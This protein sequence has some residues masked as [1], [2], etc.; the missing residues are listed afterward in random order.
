MEMVLLLAFLVAPVAFCSVLLTLVARWS[1]HRYDLTDDYGE[2]VSFPSVPADLWA[3][4]GFLLVV[5]V[6]PCLAAFAV[7]LS[8]DRRGR[9]SRLA[10]AALLVWSIVAIGDGALILTRPAASVRCA[11]CL[12]PD[13]EYFPRTSCAEQWGKGGDYFETV[14]CPAEFQEGAERVEQAIDR[15][16]IVLM[17]FGGIGVV[18]GSVLLVRTRRDG[19]GRSSQA[20]SG[21]GG[22]G[23]GSTD[24]S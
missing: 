23:E 11:A 16:A 22:P 18:A 9:G 12:D 3:L 4:R 21:G 20:G 6:L 15:D 1:N 8:A 2:T 14:P 7:A 24:P 10:C 17:A 5:V 19:A 13:G